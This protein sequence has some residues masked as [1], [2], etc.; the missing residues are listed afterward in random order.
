MTVKTEAQLR[1][2]TSTCRHWSTHW[3]QQAIIYIWATT[4]QNQ[5][6]ECAPSQDSDQAWVLS[7]PLSAQWRLITLGGC[8]G[9][10]VSSLGAQS[11]CLFCHVAAHLFISRAVVSGSGWAYML[12]QVDNGVTIKVLEFQNNHMIV[13]FDP[14]Q[15]KMF[16]SKL[17]P[18][19]VHHIASLWWS[20]IIA[21]WL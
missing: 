4:W 5:Q 2:Y 21:G 17:I 6:N 9:W 13:Y 12:S 1:L 19:F 18:D 15:G 7:Y 8:P 11:F 3:I 16:H 14:Y 10:S 20:I